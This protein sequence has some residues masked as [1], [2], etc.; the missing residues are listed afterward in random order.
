MACRYSADNPVDVI[1]LRDLL[2]IDLND[3]RYQIAI[4]ASPGKF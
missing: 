4:A 2:P 3:K 1:W